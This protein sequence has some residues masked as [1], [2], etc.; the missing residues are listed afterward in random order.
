L[1]QSDEGKWPNVVTYTTL[2]WCICKEGDM[3]SVTHWLQVMKNEEVQPN[4]VTY[5]LLVD[6][7]SKKGHR[8]RCG[9]LQLFGRFIFKE[10][11][12]GVSS[13]LAASDEK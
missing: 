1:A 2:V 12:H 9:N 11:R 13:T 7:L 10:G 8:S 4:V 3:E 5:N 6:A